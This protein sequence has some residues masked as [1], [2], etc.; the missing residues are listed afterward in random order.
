MSSP[1]VDALEQSLAPVIPAE[2]EVRCGGRITVLKRAKHAALL[3]ARKAGLFGV[4]KDSAWR[5]QRLLILCYHGISLRDE[6]EWN[7]ELYMPAGVFFRRMQMLKREG[8][9]VLPLGEAVSRLFGGTL[10]PRSVAITFDDGMFDFARQAL[11][12]LKWFDFPATVYLT[13]FY[14]EYNRPVFTL[15]CSY[16]LWKGRGRTLRINDL[17]LN[18]ALPLATPGDRDRALRLIEALSLCFSV[19]QKNAFAQEIAAQLG[20]NYR[21]IERDRMLHLV[22]PDEVRGLAEAGVDVQLHTHR[23]RVPDEP[24]LFAEEL[25]ANS[26]RIER[27]TGGKPKHF[28]YPSGIYGSRSCAW[29]RSNGMI[30]AVTCDPGLAGGHHDPLLLPRFVDTHRASE[31]E[32]ESWLTGAAAFLPRLPRAA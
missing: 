8:Y 28:C 5:D 3:L 27:W 14:S 31:L 1:S 24:A 17:G 13:T 23:H 9:N 29:L 32:F 7:P 26:T 6:H 30:S 21:E 12:I 19:D 2:R 4:A 10:P 15:L 16:L 20:V 18:A 11:P 25:L 22:N